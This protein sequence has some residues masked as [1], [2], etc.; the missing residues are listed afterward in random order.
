MVCV[1]WSGG[2]V[3][4][5]ERVAREEFVSGNVLGRV[6]RCRMCGGGCD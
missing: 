4:L 1:A 5:G 2:K 6:G 3:P